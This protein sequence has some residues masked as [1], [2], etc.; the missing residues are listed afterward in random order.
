MA[1]AL[2]S[3]ID[4]LDH[5]PRRG[6]PERS[7]RLEAV[8]GAVE[9]EINLRPER[10]EAPLA[11]AADLERVHGAAFVAAITRSAPTA[12]V[13]RLDPDTEMSPGSL[14]AALRA[15]GAAAA[16]ARDL[17][18]GETLRAFC[19]VRPPGHHAGPAF[20]M[21]F[22]IFSNI[23]IAARV[24]QA[25]GLR[26]VAIADFDVHH[27]NGTQAALQSD[28]DILFASVHESPAYPGTGD[29]SET[30]AG[31]VVN[32]VCAPGASAQTWRCAFEGLVERIDAFAPDLVLISAGFDAHHR[33]PLAHQMLEASD[34]AWATRALVSVANRHARGRIL[35][36]LEG[37]YDLQALG[38][39][40]AAHLLA[41]QAA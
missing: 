34:F 33:D 31:N 10:R 30:G 15:A 8:L 27:G 41:L 3:H 16:A 13:A 4:M 36:S 38:A 29:P 35:S 6:H 5:H 24:A 20:A 37:G 2:Y 32:A 21:G 18:A 25:G 12:G 9:A 19:A 28:P 23:A 17:A 40:A 11:A 14:K 1:V 26:R 22:C 7:E 39:S